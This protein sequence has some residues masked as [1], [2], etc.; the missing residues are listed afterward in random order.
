MVTQKV[1]LT[2][3]SDLVREPIIYNIGQQFRVVTNI[4]R[5]DISEDKGW[6]I[7]ELKGEKEE[8]H[9]AIT[10]LT[11]KGVR[12]EVIKDDVLEK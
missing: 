2:F 4:H 12:V 7:T 11:S 1:I 6:V 5:A 10:W 3:S 9:E 8:I